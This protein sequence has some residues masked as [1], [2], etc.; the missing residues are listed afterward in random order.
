MS[1]YLSWCPHG[2]GVA[3][4]FRPVQLL[5]HPA[6]LHLL[7]AVGLVAGAGVGAGLVVGVAGGGGAGRAGRAL[8]R[9]H[10]EQRVGDPAL[11]QQQRH[12][13]PVRGIYYQ[14]FI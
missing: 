10:R 11:P 5:P 12:Q 4:F 2:Q 13:Q 8:P 3:A 14:G 1:I 7:R 9:D 6:W